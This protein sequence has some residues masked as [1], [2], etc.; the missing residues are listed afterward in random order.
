MKTPPRGPLASVLSLALLWSITLDARAAE[1]ITSWGAAPEPPTLAAGPFPGTPSFS[2]QTIR[3]V[4]RLSAGGQRVRILFTNAYGAKALRIGAARVALADP[5]GDVQQAT[6]HAVLFAGE[7][8]AWVPPGAP[9]LSDPIDLP[10]APLATLSISIYLPEDTGPCTCHSVGAQT[11]YV[12]GSGDLTDKPFTPERTMLARAFIAG[13]EV[14]ASGPAK[15]IVVLGD[16]IS[17]GVGS[18]ANANRRWPDVLAERLAHQHA[19]LAWGVVNMGISGNRV[20]GDGAGQSA[21]ARMDRDVLAVPGAAYVIV[22]EGVN[23]LGIS[24]GHPSGPFAG[25]FKRFAS[26]NKATAEALI[27]GYRQIIARAH[28]KGLKVFGATITPYGGA[29]YYSEEG[30]AQ[31]QAINRWMRSSGAFDAVL[32]FDAVLRD[33]NQPTQ[34]QAALQAGDHLHGSDAGYAAL[35]RSIDLALF[36]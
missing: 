34:M 1:W 3:E 14:E 12:S 29:G 5:S 19:R 9:L 30:E 24:Y 16:S 28:A 8:S 17:D 15:S 33:P 26:G 36:K 7:P 27:A 2:N 31:R 4:V 25:Y 23:D 20:L 6:L 32:D 22:F 11:A 10:V 21:L 35:A 13:V 18:T